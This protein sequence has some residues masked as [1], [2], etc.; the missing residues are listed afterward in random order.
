MADRDRERERAEVVNPLR[1]ARTDHN[2]ARAPL[3]GVAE[4]SARCHNTN[5]IITRV[6]KSLLLLQ[7]DLFLVVTNLLFRPVAERKEHIDHLVM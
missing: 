4:V 5:K 1:G 7:Q 2:M 6:P 3:G